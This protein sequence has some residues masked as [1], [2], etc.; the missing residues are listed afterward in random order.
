MDTS[1]REKIERRA[2]EIYLRRGS[3][4]GSH[5]DDWAQA[6]KEIMAELNK[7]ET[8]AAKNDVVKNEVKEEP[9]IPETEPVLLDVKADKSKRAR[10]AVT[11][12]DMA[13]GPAKKRTVKKKSD[14]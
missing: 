11:S 14:I 1:I 12:T 2:Y 10:S 6:E 9:S 5:E 13:S 4:H 7:K 8:V 3:S